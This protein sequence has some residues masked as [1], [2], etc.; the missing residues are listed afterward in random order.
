MAGK[1]WHGLWLAAMLAAGLAI[2][3]ERQAF[4]PGSTPA[5]HRGMRGMLAVRA[6]QV[7]ASEDA[8]RLFLP[9]S[10]LKLIVAAT[11]LHHLGPEHRFQTVLAAAGP[12][13]G[14]TLGGD[15]VLQGSA[16]PTWNR[17]FFPADPRTPLRQ[18]ARQ[19]HAAGLRRVSGRLFVDTSR[20]PGP[21]FPRNRSFYERST[22]YGA[23]VS[24]VAI[25]ENVVQI[26]IAPGSAEGLPILAPE[27]AGPF[28]LMNRAVT[29]GVDRRGRGNVEFAADPERGLLIVR[30]EYPLG[31]PAY[32][33]QVSVPTPE[34]LAGEALVEALRDEGIE[35]DGSVE[36]APAPVAGL[37]PLARI[38]SP[39][40]AEILVPI[41]QKS[42]NWYAEMLLRALAMELK[43]QGRLDLG[44]DLERDFLTREV[45]LDP[46][47]F[48]LDDASG[49]SPQNLVAPEAIVAVLDYAWRQSWREAFVSAMASEGQG[50]LRGQTSLPP[51]RA[52][53]GTL[54]GVLSLAGYLHPESPD[55]T[56]FAV[57]LNHRPGQEG[58]GHAELAGLLRQ[59]EKR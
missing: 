31:E 14:G 5:A 50:T 58:S 44:L 16:D 40:L 20:F 52:K 27:R 22:W 1:P 24:P 10:V 30:G 59:W 34:R 39:P 8:A 53:T 51:L 56:I 23:P 49:L 25:D 15:L 6:G 3:Q 54:F 21:A 42:H 32:E 26:T 17:R 33:P 45:H 43:G 35:L 9:A 12:M 38:A 28:A 18:L 57:F 29:V 46:D 11:A 41:L 47:A 2:A 13:E 37:R 48:Y 19:A 36:V 7:V 55:P 4:V